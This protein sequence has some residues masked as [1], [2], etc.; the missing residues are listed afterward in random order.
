[1]HASTSRVYA[2]TLLSL[3]LP[4]ITCTFSPYGTCKHYTAIIC[5]EKEREREGGINGISETGRD[6]PAR[7][8]GYTQSL[9]YA[10]RCDALDS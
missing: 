8:T 9:M 1:M 4:I 2:C 3:L 6:R 5:V 10:V 7:E